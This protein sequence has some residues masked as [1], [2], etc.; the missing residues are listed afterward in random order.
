VTNKENNVKITAR[1]LFSRAILVK[2]AEG[3]GAFPWPG[4]YRDIHTRIVRQIRTILQG[5]AEYPYLKP[6][7]AERFAP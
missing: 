5:D 1:K 7:A 6:R 2:K 3:Y 4:S